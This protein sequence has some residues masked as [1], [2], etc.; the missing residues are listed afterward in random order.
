MSS[1]LPLASSVLKM[2][3]HK[4]P[5][6]SCLSQDRAE[7]L[8]CSRTKR[9]TSLPSQTQELRQHF[10][11]CAP[12]GPVI[13]FIS[14]MFPV[15][16]GQMPENKARPLTSEELALRREAARAKH[17]EKEASAV[18]SGGEGAVQLTG[19]QLEQL[20]VREETD[21]AVNFI[22]FARVY[23]GTLRA[24]Q[25]VWVCLLY[26]SPSPRDGLLSRMPSSA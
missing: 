15:S 7:K 25:E 10:E 26:T 16:R 20:S 12:D 4:L 5:A 3:A 11:A 13:V 6:P 21:E 24:G 19:D 2:V 17:A 9:F 22:A 8:I 23:S 1:W 18:T 14:K